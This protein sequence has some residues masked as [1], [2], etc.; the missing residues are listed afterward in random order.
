M[1][2]VLVFTNKIQRY[3]FIIALKLPSDNTANLV[4]CVYA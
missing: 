2:N 1:N 4:K 3:D